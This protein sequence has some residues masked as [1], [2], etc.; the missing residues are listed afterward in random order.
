L[1]PLR[2]YAYLLN[3]YFSEHTF[4]AIKYRIVRHQKTRSRHIKCANSIPPT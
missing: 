3:A 2:H 4:S 1:A